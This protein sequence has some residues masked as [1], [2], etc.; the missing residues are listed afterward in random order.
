M[1]CMWSS[2]HKWMTI[3]RWNRHVGCIRLHVFSLHS[4]RF[5]CIMWSEI[6]WTFGQIWWHKNNRN[7]YMQHICNTTNICI[8]QKQ[9]KYHRKSYDINIVLQ[10][11]GNTTIQ[12]FIA[13]SKA[14]VICELTSPR[15]FKG[16]TSS[17]THCA[18][19]IHFNYPG[20]WHFPDKW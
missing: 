5:G 14:E 7:I 9:E 13:A 19:A 1:I 15:R 11:E 4:N 3:C 2:V 8:I 6:C 12:G 17:I 10:R 18:Q 16:I 20:G